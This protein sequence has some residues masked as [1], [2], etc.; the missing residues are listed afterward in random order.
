MQGVEMKDDLRTD[1]DAI[2]R[3]LGQLRRDI[4]ELTSGLVAAGQESLHSL[5]D[6]LKSEV[7]NRTEQAR[8]AGHQA[9]EKTRH[10][11]EERPLVSVGSALAVGL[12]IGYLLHRKS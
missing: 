7:K 11:I 2:R 9:V 1:V 5:N 8:D 12:V 4:G 10:T 6:R 3:D